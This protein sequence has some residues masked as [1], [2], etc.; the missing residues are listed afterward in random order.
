MNKYINIFHNWLEIPKVV[1]LPRFLM[2]H[3][4]S[5]MYIHN[6]YVKILKRRKK[7]LEGSTGI[8]AH[9]LHVTGRVGQI[10]PKTLK[11]FITVKYAQ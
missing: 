3:P 1:T 8:R 10:T 2:E 9:D 11:K 4:V 6:N 7:F 5:F